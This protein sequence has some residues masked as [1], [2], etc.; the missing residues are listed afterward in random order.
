MNKLL[1]QIL[2]ILFCLLLVACN[3]QDTN[4]NNADVSIDDEKEIAEDENL[5][6][7]ESEEDR[8]VYATEI[9][10]SNALILGGV[11]YNVINI[12]YEKRIA[13]VTRSYLSEDSKTY[14]SDIDGSYES[15]YEGSLCHQYMIDYYENLPQ[16]VK[17]DIIP[18]T[19][20]ETSLGYI[21]VM[22]PNLL[23]LEPL[24]NQYVYP[25]SITQVYDEDGEEYLISNSSKDDDAVA[26][27]EGYDIDSVSHDS[28]A[29]QFYYWSTY[30]RGSLH[31]SHL[32]DY[33]GEVSTA[34][35]Y[36]SEDEQKL[37]TD[38]Q[39]SSCDVEHYNRPTFRIKLDNIHESQV[40]NRPY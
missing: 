17:D 40:V 31:E 28:D 32:R 9:H 7:E 36:Y 14:F 38:Y 13:E 15:V 11:L 27:L 39:F 18:I 19:L 24:E 22:W 2:S 21:Q 34:G 3:T 35:T 33:Y 37:C 12:D 6:E 30:S 23:W 5:S 1:K 4:S 10:K 29:P 25:Y 20:Y 16:E 8:I 26:L